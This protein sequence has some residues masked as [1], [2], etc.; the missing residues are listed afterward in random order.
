M[1]AQAERTTPEAALVLLGSAALS[2]CLAV[3]VSFLLGSGPCA[4][5]LGGFNWVVLRGW[6]LQAKTELLTSLLGRL[7]EEC[8][9][10]GGLNSRNLFLPVLG[11][12]KCDI[13]SV[14]MAGSF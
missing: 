5:G 2:G 8:H 14:G 6:G 7:Q 3:T 1:G 12:K 4:G 11:G 9:R 10:M 13:K